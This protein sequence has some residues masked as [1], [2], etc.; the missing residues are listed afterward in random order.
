MS[1]GF[2][3]VGSIKHELIPLPFRRK[4]GARLSLTFV[5]G[6]EFEIAGD[7]PYIELHGVPIYLEDF[8]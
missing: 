4:V 3:E 2:L 1:E 6:G 7:K 5:D 8:P